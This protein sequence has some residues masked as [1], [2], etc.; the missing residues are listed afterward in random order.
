MDSRF[1]QYVVAVLGSMMF[2]FIAFAMAEP[3]I[4]FAFLVVSGVFLMAIV[5]Y[6]RERRRRR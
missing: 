6:E 5:Y 3:P 2:A 4:R 1:V